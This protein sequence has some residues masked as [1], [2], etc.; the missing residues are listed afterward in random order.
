[1]IRIPAGAILRP[2]RPASRMKAH[3]SGA[4]ALSATTLAAVAAGLAMAVVC[5]AVALARPDAT[6]VPVRQVTPP[7]VT[8]APLP[9]LPAEMPWC[10]PLATGPC[11]V[12]TA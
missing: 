12:V 2:G 10:G 11:R 5:L 6:P 4:T 3:I 9:T 1:V 7:A 8:E